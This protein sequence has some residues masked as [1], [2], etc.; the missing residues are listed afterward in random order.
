MDL[1]AQEN[2]LIIEP[3]VNMGNGHLMKFHKELTEENLVG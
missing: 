1:F 3:L 2:G